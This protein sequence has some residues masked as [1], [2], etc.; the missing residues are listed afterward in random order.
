MANKKS[1]AIVLAGSAMEA[2]FAQRETSFW[3]DEII[4]N[5]DLQREAHLR[6]TLHNLLDQVFKREP[7]ATIEFSTTIET[8]AI[9]E[10]TAIDIFDSLADFLDA[11][12]L[13][14]RLILYLPFELLPPKKWQA[15]KILQQ[16]S[17]RFACTYMRSWY[18]LLEET[19]VRENFSR[20]N[21][22][23]KEIAPSGQPLVRKA[24]HLIPILARKGFL[25]VKEI[26]G[27]MDTASS[28]VLRDSIA[29]AL[30]A[31]VSIPLLTLQECEQL[32]STRGYEMPPQQ[33]RANERVL[34]KDWL[35]RA[36]EEI[37][38]EL[39]KIEM[40]LELDRSRGMPPA[41]VAWEYVDRID[42]I[43]SAYGK[44]IARVVVADP[45]GRDEIF[46]FLSMKYPTAMVVATMRGMRMAVEILAQTKRPEAE[47]LANAYLARVQDSSFEAPIVRDEL[48][49]TLAH[50]KNILIIDTETL[51]R[52]G[53]AV[54]NLEIGFESSS[55][56][57][58]ELIGF[59]D[60]I[61]SISKNPDYE[62]L[63]YPVAV[64]FGSRLKGYA[65]R[66]ADL[67]VAVFVKPDITES[68]RRTVRRALSQMF[69]GRGIDGKV[70]EFWLVSNTHGLNIRD[71]DDPDV[72]QGD[73]T[74]AH[75][76]LESVW[77]GRADTIEM[78]Y[79][80]LLPGFLYQSGETF[81]GRDLRKLR[82]D[83]LEREVLQYRL[84]HK[85]YRRFF[86]P[87]GGIEPTYAGGIDPD[88]VFWDS[89]Y[90]RLASKLFL[91]RVFL[92]R[93][94]K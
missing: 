18:A 40:R 89:G 6:H 31:L 87:T 83:E 32:L 35:Q 90:R 41:R 33:A 15:A 86:P 79:R 52:F 67:D 58:D 69:A 14:R 37:A 36:P 53:Y 1:P 72:F 29:D 25:S 2:L 92:P 10:T 5:P 11:D 59:S 63:I 74:W 43:A 13:H 26:I 50:W 30:P 19:D 46:S 82:L 3:P 49:S 38:Y 64:F 22:L 85:G 91:R 57:A 51:A 23:E 39:R 16:A 44:L 94:T 84:M 88:S 9:S 12:P 76:L 4:H 55:P 20:G 80:E 45:G 78:L 73:R 42:Q 48:E 8:G 17:E 66:D 81:L 56:L 7:D 21:I 27:L 77:L 62:H 34:G 28:D 24:A 54:P 70:V 47:R 75:I 93:L 61:E 71:F 60:I 68:E 65:K